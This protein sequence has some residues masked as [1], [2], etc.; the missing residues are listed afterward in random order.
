MKKCDFNANGSDVEKKLT[1][2]SLVNDRTAKKH[3]GMNTFF[4]FTAGV[5]KMVFI[6]HIE[7]PC[8]ECI[9]LTVGCRVVRPCTVEQSAQCRTS[10]PQPMY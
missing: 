7:V 4:S 3:W 10:C 5:E 6:H 8:S 2:I 1:D 9:F